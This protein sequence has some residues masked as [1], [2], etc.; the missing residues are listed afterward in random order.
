ML[1]DVMWCDV[2]LLLGVSVCLFRVALTQLACMQSE[3][4]MFVYPLN[5]S[6][7]DCACHL[8]WS[9]V[10]AFILSAVLRAPFR[11]FE[12]RRSVASCNAGY[13]LK[14]RIVRELLLYSSTFMFSAFDRFV[15]RFSGKW[16]IV[17]VAWLSLVGYLWRDF[18]I[19]TACF[20]S[21]TDVAKCFF[22]DLELRIC[23]CCCFESLF[24]NLK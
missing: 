13:S 8:L 23:F 10:Q 11:W 24:G 12:P 19:F 9:P 15:I 17:Y 6:Q 1:C 22:Y 3:V 7:P 5:R 20:L 4:C 21:F 2:M 14:W 16:G 18:S